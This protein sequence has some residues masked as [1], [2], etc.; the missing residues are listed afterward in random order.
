MKV[1][2]NVEIPSFPEL[3]YLATLSEDFYAKGISSIDS[4]AGLIRGRPF[5]GVAILW[6]KSI[7]NVCSVIE[8]DD[9]CLLGI[10][11]EGDNFDIQVLNVYLPYSD[12]LNI[13]EY[14]FY[15]SKIKSIANEFS[16]PYIYI[17]GDFNANISAVAEGQIHVKVH[18]IWQTT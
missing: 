17:V 7:A 12:E 10:K 11:L 3:P 16:S 6:Q 5:G 8:Y 15:L 9:T 2:G 13:D 1:F 4:S 14:R 18:A